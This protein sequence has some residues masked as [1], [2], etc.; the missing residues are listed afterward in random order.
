MVD[1]LVVTKE[2][3]V[4]K[5]FAEAH[6][7]ILKEAPEHVR[8]PAIAFMADVPELQVTRSPDEDEKAEAEDIVTTP[9][10]R[11]YSS[12][13]LP[14]PR[15]RTRTLSSHDPFTHARRSS[16]FSINSPSS[17][18]PVPISVGLGTASTAGSFAQFP[19]VEE[20]EG[21]T[22]RCYTPTTIPVR[23]RLTSQVD[24]SDSG[25][26]GRKDS[27][28]A[29]RHLR[30][31]STVSIYESA[32]RPGGLEAVAPIGKLVGV[33]KTAGAEGLPSTPPEELV[34]EGKSGKSSSP[35]Q[36]SK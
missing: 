6:G 35:G 5:E 34:A 11:S 30:T 36:P 19:S 7:H 13:T 4:T 12:A 20:P 24:A 28:N 16:I 25:T 31:L 9:D 33:V 26:I 21:P 18:V 1:E 32:S 27:A 3:L 8:D 10:R 23:Q 17:A 14:L 15:A 29:Y 2:G 22:D